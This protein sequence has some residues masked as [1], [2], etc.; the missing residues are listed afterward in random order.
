MYGKGTEV[1][2]AIAGREYTGTIEKGY[3]A[4][5]GG[6]MYHAHLTYGTGGEPGT[7]SY[8]VM[9]DN[10]RLASYSDAHLASAGA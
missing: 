10:V 7:F 9:A 6:V 8:A 3:N 2:V 4:P 1:I 5:S